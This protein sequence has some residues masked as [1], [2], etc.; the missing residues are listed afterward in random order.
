MS[1]HPPITEFTSPKGRRFIVAASVRD[2]HPSRW[3]E[4]FAVFLVTTDI[5]EVESVCLSNIY[6]RDGQSWSGQLSRLRWTPTDG[7]RDLPPRAGYDVS[8][9]PTLEECVQAW[10]KSADEILD[11]REAKKA[12]QQPAAPAAKRGKKKHG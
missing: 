5:I 1:L 10:A 9:F 12:S 7:I 4:D 6:V 11:Y 2:E 3:V 8:H